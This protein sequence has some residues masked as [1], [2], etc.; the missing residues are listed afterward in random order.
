M[1]LFIMRYKVVLT[2]ANVDKTYWVAAFQL[3]AIE[4]YFHEVLFVFQVFSSGYLIK[5]LSDF[6]DTLMS[7]LMMSH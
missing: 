1:G 2:L 7:S 3:K 6:A 5:H 4:Q